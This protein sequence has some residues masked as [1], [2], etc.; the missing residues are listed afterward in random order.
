M[1][2]VLVSPTKVVLWYKSTIKAALSEFDVCHQKQLHSLF[3]N[4]I[5]VFC[6]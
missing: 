5:I 4:P 3:P 2:F 6:N 1:I